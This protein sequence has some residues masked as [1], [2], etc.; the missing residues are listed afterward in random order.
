MKLFILVL[1]IQQVVGLNIL[2]STK[3]SWVSK[4]VRFLYAALK[5]EGHNVV[6]IAPL[7]HNPN[8]YDEST[9][10]RD[11]ANSDSVLDGGDFGHLLAAHQTY[12][13]N[14]RKLVTVPRGAKNVISKK[15]E[16][17][18]L[19]L[20]E[21]EATSNNL[22]GQDPLDEN[23]W[24]I[25]ASPLKM[26]LLAYDL[27]L[28]TYYPDFK[29]DLVVLG[30]NEGAAYTPTES[31]D[32][33]LFGEDVH[34]AASETLTSL[35]KLT[36]L[37]H[38][39]VLAISTEDN[40]HIYYQDEHYFKIQQRSWQKTLKR[41]TF[42]KNV[43][44]INHRIC[45]FISRLPTEI[46]QTLSLNINFPSLNHY[47]SRCTTKSSNHYASKTNPK[48]GQVIAT[49]KT[50]KNDISE[51]MLP[52]Y[53]IVDGELVISG[54]YPAAPLPSSE[55]DTEE[56]TF[57]DKTSLYYK[58]KTRNYT[59]EEL[60]SARAPDRSSK[61]NPPKEINGVKQL[62]DKE[63][64]YKYTHTNADEDMALEKCL[65]AVS[66]NHA[67]HGFGLDKDVFDIESLF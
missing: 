37:K 20:A 17:S 34:I 11:D 31:S 22:F 66:V 5:E 45:D 3:D 56:S 54:N 23:I 16:E 46:P 27:V 33:K 57:V 29:P 47:Y 52:K 62:T 8:L 18:A 44:F 26:L 4:N 13:K 58:H 55:D 49:K 9:I 6:M 61:F 32:F 63:V 65:I 60:S 15:A 21:F 28:P 64:I 41:N 30:P 10:R 7:Y 39:P 14:L 2:L 24:Y 42:S 12:Y 25:N 51:V 1:L 53:E 59:P 35:V 38:L 36:N 19:A 67:E 40:H 43:E 48:F 50:G